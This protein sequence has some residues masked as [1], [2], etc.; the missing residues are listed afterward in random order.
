MIRLRPARLRAALLAPALAPLLA[1]AL[2]PALAAHDYWLELSRYRPEAGGGLLVSHR[3]GEKLDGEAVPRN[4]LAIVRFDL[5]A[6]DGTSTPVPGRDGF[7]PAGFLKVD[8]AGQARIVFQSTRSFVELLPEKFSAY[9]ALEG[10]EKVERERQRLGK[11][12]ELAR[13]AFSRSAAALVCIG[14]KDGS[15]AAAAPLPVGLDLEIVPDVDLCA[16]HAG[17][18]IAFRILFRGKPIEGLLVMALSRTPGG[19]PLSAR[20]DRRGRVR[21]KLSAPGFWLIKA[22]EM[23]PLAGVA[24]ADWESFWASLTFEMRQSVP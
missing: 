17:E 12:K 19:T 3:V 6:A 10:L 4:P 20:S 14:G 11:G 9:L 23:R 13:E 24:N 22:V 16:S 15:V 2:A 7:D 18:E 8:T 21:F 5:I 1:L